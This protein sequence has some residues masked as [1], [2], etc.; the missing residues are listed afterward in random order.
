LKS[1]VGVRRFFPLCSLLAMTWSELTW[2]M[3][4]P[5]RLEDSHS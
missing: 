2:T 4:Y 5:D 3:R 1:A